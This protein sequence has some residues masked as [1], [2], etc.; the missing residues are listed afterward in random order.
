MHSQLIVSGLGLTAT[1]SDPRRD[2]GDARRL[3]ARRARR[4][5][6]PGCRRPPG[7]LPQVP[8]GARRHR[9]VAAL[10]GNSTGDTP[11]AAP[12]DL[13]QRIAASLQMSPGPRVS[14][15]TKLPPEARVGRAARSRRRRAHAHGRVVAAKVG[16]LGQQVNSLSTRRASRACCSILL[17]EPSSSHPPLTRSGGHRGLLPDGEGYLINP[18]MP[19][20]V[21]SQTFQLWALS[22]GKVVS[23]GVLGSHPTGAPIRVEPP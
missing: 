9:E 7:H 8:S 21:G 5:R 10:L 22:R 23:L 16:S 13:W 17:T 19:A 3:C 2:R 12:D 18:S 6:A 4:R 15:A 14:T 20:L 11:A 1:A